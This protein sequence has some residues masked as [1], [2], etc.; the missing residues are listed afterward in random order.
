M[1]RYRGIL[2]R[3]N[4]WYYRIQHQGKRIESRGFLAA[5]DA[6]RAR[7]KQLEKLYSRDLVHHNITLVEFVAVY[8]EQY[9]TV[10]VRRAT[11]HATESVARNHILPALGALRL[12]DLK[13]YHIIQFQNDVV[14]TRTPSTAH[15]VMKALR[16]ILN[17]AVEW[18]YIDHSPLKGRIPPDR[19]NEYP[20]LEL[21]DLFALVDRLQGREKVIVA[22]AGFAALRRSEIFGLRWEDIDF[23]VGTLSLQ[24]Q[25]KNGEVSALKTDGSAAIIP[26]WSRLL[27]IL[28]E[29]R[30]KSGSPEWVF[31]G[32]EGPLSGHGWH[33]EFWGKIKRQC[34]LPRRLR[35]HDLRHT[36]ASIMLSGGAAPGDVQKLLRHASYAT[37]MNIYRH[38]MPGQLEKN[39]EIFDKSKSMPNASIQP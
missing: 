18:E 11:H 25:Y 27:R 12:Q 2:K 16:K 3:K 8:F 21:L 5:E 13:S 10:S 26:L 22:L 17:K 9:G 28:M 29:W 7:T 33:N 31:P 32:Q 1:P 30:L 4:L 38:I 14:R 34:G 20:V 35:L 15:N 19:R 36:F 23:K 24:R 39:F 37:T 6:Y